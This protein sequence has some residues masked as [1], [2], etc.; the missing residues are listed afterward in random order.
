MAGATSRRGRRVR[1]CRPMFEPLSPDNWRPQGP[2]VG[3]LD[4]EY[5]YLTPDATYS[6]IVQMAR[7]QGETFNLTQRTLWKRLDER[8]LPTICQ[9]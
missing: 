3:W 5:L 9:P 2:R 4:D 8:G 6:A 1:L 7:E